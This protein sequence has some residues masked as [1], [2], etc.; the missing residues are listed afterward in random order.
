MLSETKPK[1]A[2]A[3]VQQQ[4]HHV[5][6]PVEQ[7]QASHH[8]LMQ[9]TVP[10]GRMDRGFTALGF[11]SGTVAG[12]VGVLVGYPLDTLKVR[13]QV[14]GPVWGAGSEQLSNWAHLR[15]LYR[16][17]LAPTATAGAIQ[18]VNFGVYENFAR[19]LSPDGRVTGAS[20]Q[21]VTL[22]GMAGGLAISPFTCPQQRLKIHQQLGGGTL[23]ERATDLYRHKG[24]AG[25][26][27][28]YPL[29]SV[30]EACRGVYM[31]TYVGVKRALQGDADEASV[32]LWHRMLAGACAGT[33]GWALVYPADVVKSVMQAEAASADQSPNV[34]RCVRMLLAEGG[35]ARFYRGFAYTLVRAGPVAASLLPTYD[36]TLRALSPY[37]E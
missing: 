7:L 29:H 19:K 25:F 4:H 33:V 24:V 27:R 18:C 13:A 14:G 17:S 36:L 3:V 12:A 22:A 35:V 6:V 21:S 28:G 11:I 8:A 23:W 20:L 31:A 34:T 15:A 2:V 5:T 26:Y 16:G 9:H 1:Q 30:M 32:L 10:A 37:V